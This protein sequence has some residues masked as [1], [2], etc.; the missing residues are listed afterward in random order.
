MAG[1]LERIGDLAKNIAK[2]VGTV[3]LSATPRDLS[4]SIDAMPLSAGC[5]AMTSSLRTPSVLSAVLERID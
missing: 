3:G 1:D 5:R 2:R 4:H